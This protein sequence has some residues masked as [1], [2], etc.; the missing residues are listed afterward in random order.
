MFTLLG[1]FG[2]LGLMIAYLIWDK[3]RKDDERDK[4]QKERTEADKALAASLA[5]LTVT[6]QHLAQRSER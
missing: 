1:Q 3:S 4:I 2:P 5:A 6:I